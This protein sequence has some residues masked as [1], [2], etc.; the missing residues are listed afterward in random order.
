MLKHVNTEHGGQCENIKFAWKVLRKH[1]KPLQ[2][3]L[4]EAVNISKKD[5]F[6]HLNSK[7]EF[8]SQSVER[9]TLNGSKFTINCKIC[10]QLSRTRYEVQNHE[11]KFHNRKPCNNCNYISFGQRDLY[12]HKF[13]SHT[14]S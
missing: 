11:D 6:K 12:E 2:R 3:Q 7:S 4:H 8:N 14:S 5:P 13:N 9:L 1:N 10:G